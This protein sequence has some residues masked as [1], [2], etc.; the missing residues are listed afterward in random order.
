MLVLLMGGIYEICCG[1]GLGWNYK[2]IMFYNDQ[3]RHSSNVKVIASTI[4][5]GAVLVLLIAGTHEASC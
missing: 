3:F 1:D 2:H 5:E 4:S